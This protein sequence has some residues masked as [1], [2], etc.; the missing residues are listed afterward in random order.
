MNNIVHKF[1]LQTFIKVRKYLENGGW[2]G[3]KSRGSRT[4]VI[5]RDEY[6]VGTKKK[7]GRFEL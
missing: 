3:V 7:N 4:R 2:R 5:N 6:W 1:L